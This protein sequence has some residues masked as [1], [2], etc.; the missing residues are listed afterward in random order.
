MPGTN[1]VSRVFNVAAMLWL[2]SMVDVF[3][4]YLSVRSMCAVPRTA[5]FCNVFV[6]SIVVI[7]IVVVMII[8]IINN[9]NALIF[10]VVSRST[11]YFYFGMVYCSILV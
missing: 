2:Q 10:S 11:S 1:H 3:C 8:I 9:Y 5:L 6:I 4:F 7:I